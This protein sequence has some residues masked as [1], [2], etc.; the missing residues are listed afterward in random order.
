[1]TNLIMI[2]FLNTFTSRGKHRILKIHLH[3][4]YITVELVMGALIEL[5]YKT[6]FH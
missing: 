5:V 1:M 2:I 6:I 3:I 4:A